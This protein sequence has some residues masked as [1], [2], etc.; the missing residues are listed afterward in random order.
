M[1]A[2]SASSSRHRSAFLTG[3][4]SLV[5]Q[6]FFFHLWIQRLDALLDV[7]RVG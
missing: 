1:R 7:L 3:L 4:R 2:T 6:P 5:R